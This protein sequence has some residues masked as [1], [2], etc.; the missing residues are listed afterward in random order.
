MASVPDDDTQ[1]WLDQ[2]RRGIQKPLTA[3]NLLDYQLCPRKFLLAS[4]A[5]ASQRRALGAVRALHA[6]VRAA[7]VACDRAGGP[8]AVTLE[9][10]RDEFRRRFDGRACADSLEEEQTLKL[11]LAILARWH[12]AQRENSTELVAADVLISAQ[13]EDLDFV[14]TADRVER[15]D[16]GRLVVARY[17]VRARP[18]SARKL[19]Q[20]FSFGLLVALAEVH[21][22][23]RPLARLYALRADRVIDADIPDQRLGEVRRLALTVARAI[24][25]DATFEA[26]P[27][28][29]CIWCRVR[30]T[31]PQWQD[32]RRSLLAPGGR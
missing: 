20:D 10:L 9:W 23:Q 22:G 11:G 27:G 32:R 6:A 5:P 21:Y 18:P 2:A 25:A 14:A 8:S 16:D 7:L 1:Q 17:D 29:H 3:S 24:R 4:F 13:I 31:C 28:D 30:S 15:T 26:R 19:A 12:A